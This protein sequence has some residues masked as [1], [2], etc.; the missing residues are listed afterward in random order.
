MIYSKWARGTHGFGQGYKFGALVGALLGFGVGMIWFA[1]SNFMTSTG[2][3][4]DAVYQVVSYG[5]AGGVMGIV[6][7]KMDSD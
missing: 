2:H 7:D 6:Y 3:I 4:I 5:I 1:T